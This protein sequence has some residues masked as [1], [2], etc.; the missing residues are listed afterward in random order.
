VRGIDVSQTALEM[1]RQN[2]AQRGLSVQFDAAD[3]CG[4]PGQPERYDLVIDGHCLHCL[5]YDE[6]RREA[7]A[8]IGRLLK[9]DGL[10]LIETMVSHP[11]LRVC[12]RSR[13]MD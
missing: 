2:A 7:L 9:A 8:A 5:V 3:I 1:A 4:L 13:W 10:F 12:C 6:H 11:I